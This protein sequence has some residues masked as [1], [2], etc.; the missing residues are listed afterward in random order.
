MVMLKVCLVLVISIDIDA[1]S[2]DVEGVDLAGRLA[3]WTAPAPHY[4]SGV[5]AKYALLVGSASRGART[6]GERPIEAE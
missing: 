3:T 6:T 2:L 5:L 1:R 4:R